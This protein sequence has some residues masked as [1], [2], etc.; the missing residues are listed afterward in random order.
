MMKHMNVNE[1]YH[2]ENN[3]GWLFAITFL[4]T[5]IMALIALKYLLNFVQKRIFLDF[6]SSCL[7]YSSSVE[8]CIRSQCAIFTLKTGL[9]M[10]GAI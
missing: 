5:T 9:C 8:T 10:M 4:Y 1:H 2:Y 3:A 6:S 7:D